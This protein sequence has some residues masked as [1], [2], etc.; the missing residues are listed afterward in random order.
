MLKPPLSMCWPAP[1]S[2]YAWRS[3]ATLGLDVGNFNTLRQLTP[4]VV[5]PARSVPAGSATLKN[6]TS[7]VKTGCLD[8]LASRISELYAANR[9]GA[10][11]M[12]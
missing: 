11:L 9:G 4:E 3:A 5:V 2:Y 7:W 1:Y 12:V 10:P 8:A 6:S